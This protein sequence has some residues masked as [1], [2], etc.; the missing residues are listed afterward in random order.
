[1]TKRTALVNTDVICAIDLGGTNLRAA[2]VDEGGKI[3]SRVQHETPQSAKSP[4]ELMQALVAAVRECQRDLGERAV[5]KAAAV[6][7]PGT[8]D[9]A[10]K[11]V[12]QVPN[13]PCLD[14]FPLKQ[15]L[16]K[17]LAWPVVLE[18]DANAAALG[19]MWQG[20][21]RGYATIV[22]LTLGT[23][24]G[25]GIILQGK[26]W[27]GADGAAGEVGHTPV[28]PQGGVKCKCGST[29]CLEVYASATA[30][31]RLTREALP[32]FPASILSGEELSARKVYDAGTRGDA[33]AIEVLASMGTFLGIGVANL[34]NLLNPEIIVIGGKV[35]NA[36]PLFANHM[37]QEILA[38]AFSLPA[39]RVKIVPAECGDDAGLL[40]AAW[41]ALDE[42]GAFHGG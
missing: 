16:A 8:V 17:E 19:E 42:V 32:R 24:V 10:N 22:C 30:I 36:W 6:V 12:V 20:A 9:S 13:I 23:G 33:L 18:N 41:L 37:H 7:V 29:G 21:A 27:R 40:G 38:R 1:M 4:E 14:N 26:L 5:I 11:I 34:I 39:Q 15:A 3:L 31:V 35:A 2:F 28:D 25:G